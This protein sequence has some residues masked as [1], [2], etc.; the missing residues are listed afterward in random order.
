[1]EWMSRFLI[2]LQI[3]Y[4]FLNTSLIRT[5]V[6]FHFILRSSYQIETTLLVSLKVHS[7]TDCHAHFD[8]VNRTSKSLKPKFDR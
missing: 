7:S 1:M 8:L 2:A 6:L 3:N 4:L 5:Y